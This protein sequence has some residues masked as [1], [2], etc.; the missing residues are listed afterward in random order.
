MELKDIMTRNVEVLPPNATVQEAARVMK[1]LDVGAVP[2]CD[3]ERLLGIV[4][5]RDI[6]I[7]STAAG[8][9]PTSTSVVETMTPQILYCYED[10]S[11]KEAAQIMGANQIRRL[12]VLNREKKLVGIVSLGDLSVDAGRDKLTGQTLE[13]IS[14]PS[15][16]ER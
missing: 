11:V 10:Q 5:D 7:R 3:G 14:K 4:T 16:P 13:D 15:E 12:P 1:D 2:V 6:T 8:L 9:D